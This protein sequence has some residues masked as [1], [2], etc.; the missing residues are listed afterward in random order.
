MQQR[1]LSVARLLDARLLALE[2]LRRGLEGEALVHVDLVAVRVSQLLKVPVVVSL[3][4]VVSVALQA[5]LRQDATH[6]V[7]M[8]A[9][10]PNL[11]HCSTAPR[12]LNGCLAGGGSRWFVCRLLHC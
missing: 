9:C 7:P 2:D 10:L 8:P 1:K 12:S 5:V 11:A 6:P 4:R 3:L